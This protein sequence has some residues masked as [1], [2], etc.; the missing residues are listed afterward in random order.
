MNELLFKLQTRLDT[1]EGQALAE[2]ALILTFI[3][4]VAVI[5]VGLL[6]L[7]IAGAFGSI[8]PSF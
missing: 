1:D 8:V 5:V 7:A 2:Y 3:L 4:A 6:G